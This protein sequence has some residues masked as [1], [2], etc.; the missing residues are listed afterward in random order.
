MESRRLHFV[1][2]LRVLVVLLLL[3]FH[4]TRVFNS[5]EDFY[6]KGAEAADIADRLIAFIDVWG[7]P[8]LFLLAGVSTNLALRKRT[9]S[10]YAV[11]R[12]KRLLVPL[13]FG[14]I[15]LIPPQTWYGGRFHSGYPRS[16]LEYLLSG[17]FLEWNIQEG[18]DYYGGFGVGHLWFVAF[19]LLISLVTLPWWRR[20]GLGSTQP[21]RAARWL[22]HPLGWLA[23]GGLIY[24]AEGL[25]GVAGKNLFYYWVFFVLGYGAAAGP[26]FMQAAERYRWPALLGGG[27][28]TAWWVMSSSF[29]NSLADP[30]LELAAVN[31]AGMTAR[32]VLIV[33]LIGLARR[34]LDHPSRSLAYLAEGSYAIYLLHQTVIVV[35]AFYVVDVGA[36]WFGQWLLLLILATVATFA[37][38]EGVR[39]VDWLRLMF[40]MRPQAAGSIRATAPGPPGSDRPFATTSRR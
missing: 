3:P 11:E 29:R 40:G 16:Y 12:L 2:W 21:G 28:V 30:S 8:L 19:L 15:V 9:K 20:T 1:D 14:V 39:R 32:F 22:A 31:L 34:Y 13:V 23:A 38:Y 27:T 17:D 37:A 35:L 5:D 18:G 25:P 36:G 33:G 4:T 10:E 26:D 6:V 7:M 24:L